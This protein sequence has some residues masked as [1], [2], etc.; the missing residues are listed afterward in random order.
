MCDT[1]EKP[2]LFTTLPPLDHNALFLRKI[3]ANMHVS[4]MQIKPNKLLVYNLSITSEIE[5][6]S[7][8]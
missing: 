3:I 7:I 6:M 1:W 8:L 5:G 2:L 4:G